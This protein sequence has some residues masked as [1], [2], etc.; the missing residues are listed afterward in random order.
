[1]RIATRGIVRAL[2]HNIH[3]TPKIPRRIDYRRGMVGISLQYLLEIKFGIGVFC[4]FANNRSRRNGIEKDGFRLFRRSIISPKNTNQIIRRKSG[5]NL[6][7][8][9]S[10]NCILPNGFLLPIPPKK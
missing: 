9:F 6:L 5:L 8:G 10:I 2:W 4:I 1:M 3:R 7:Q